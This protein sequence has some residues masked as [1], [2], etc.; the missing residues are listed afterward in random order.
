MVKPKN[1]ES[2]PEIPKEHSEEAIAAKVAAGLSREFAI[3][4]LDAQAAHDATNPHDPVP[5]PAKESKE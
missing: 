5:E 2:A 1:T 3:A 4:A